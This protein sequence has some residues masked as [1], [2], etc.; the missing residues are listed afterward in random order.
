MLVDACVEGFELRYSQIV[1]LG[2]I[3]VRNCEF[4]RGRAHVRDDHVCN[5]HIAFG[6]CAGR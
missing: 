2:T 6:V 3:N 4:V 5:G 1:I